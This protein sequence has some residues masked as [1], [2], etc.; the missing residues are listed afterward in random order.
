[1]LFASIMEELGESQPETKAQQLTVLG[2]CGAVAVWHLVK[3]VLLHCERV[4][5]WVFID[6][7]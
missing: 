3:S 6:A 4:V 1:M 2:T 7:T 5:L